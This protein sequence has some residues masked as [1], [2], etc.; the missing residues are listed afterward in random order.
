VVARGIVQ[1]ELKSQIQMGRDQRGMAEA[2]LDLFQRGPA[3][4]RQFGMR[5]AKVVRRQIEPAN[6]G[7]RFYD[8]EDTL[9]RNGA[10][11]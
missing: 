8:V 10:P 3:L 6:G 5:P 1:V 7:V 9:G 2:N 4:V 11:S